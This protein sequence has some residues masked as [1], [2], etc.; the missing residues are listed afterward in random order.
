MKI[1]FRLISLSLICL[2]TL[3]AQASDDKLSEFENL[4]SSHQGKVIYLDFWASW[5]VPCRKSFPW[6]N[7]M[8]AKHSNNNFTVLSVNL[9]T[10]RELAAKFLQQTPAQFPIF[11]DP[12]GKVAKAFKLKGMPSSF[13]INKQG[14]IVSRHVG[15]TE[16]K[17]LQYQQEILALIAAQ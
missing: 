4:V 15:F 2:T 12:K 5:C 17:Q 14:K 6:M 8:Q 9:D 3:T 7:E 16:Q 1:I 10:N 13:I 11:Y